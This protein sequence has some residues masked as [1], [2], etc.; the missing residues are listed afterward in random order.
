MFD[1]TISSAAQIE[2]LDDDS[3]TVVSNSKTQKDTSALSL[4]ALMYDESSDSEEEEFEVH[5]PVKDPES[6]GSDC[7]E[8]V[9][10]GQQELG[11]FRIDS[12]NDDALKISN[13]YSKHDT[14]RVGNKDKVYQNLDYSDEFETDNCKLVDLNSLTH[15]FRNFT[16]LQNGASSCNPVASKDEATIS[17]ALVPL[18][19]TTTS[20][21]PKSDEES[22]RM[23]VFCLQHA[24]QVEQRLNSFGGA[25]I[26]LVSHPGEM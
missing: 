26:F 4:L 15:S 22:S 20:F 12:G 9:H 21:A 17:T 7:S 1:V 14:A 23:H 6:K 8:G 25:R 3:T 2:T 16:K 24:V 18:E 19:M 11:Y 13:S 5:I 10:E